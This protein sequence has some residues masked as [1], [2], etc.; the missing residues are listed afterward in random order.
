MDFEVVVLNLLKTNLRFSF[1]IS[2]KK[3]PGWGLSCTL[4]INIQRSVV[5]GED[6]R[7]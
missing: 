3:T 5:D 7:L 6:F 1:L 2:L 4:L